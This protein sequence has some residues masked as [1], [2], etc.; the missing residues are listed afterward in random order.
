M[1]ANWQRRAGVAV[2]LAVVGY[3]CALTA[4]VIGQSPVRLP[5]TTTERVAGARWWP[6]RM[7]PM[8]EYAGTGVCA[9]CHRS[10]VESQSRSNMARTLSPAAASEVLR[11]RELLRFTASP[12]TH[13]IKTRNGESTYSVSD[14][15]RTAAVALRWAFGAGKVGQTFLFERGRAMHEGRASYFG[16]IEAL[17]Q[18]PGRA[19]DRPADV[20]SAMGRRLSAGE[21]A[22]CFGCHTSGLSI[23]DGRVEDAVPG[24]TCE[25]CH[26]PGKAHTD[27]M[28]ANRDEQGLAA[29]LNPA[30][31]HPVD[32]VDFCGACHA[33]Y[34]DVTLANEKGIR[35]MRSQPFRLQSS[36]CWD[37]GDRRITCVACH[38]PHEPL[39]REAGAYDARCLSCH[40][41][42]DGA[43]RPAI[44]DRPV[45]HAPA[46]DAP[47][48]RARQS[49]GC[50][51]CH[52]PKYQVAEMHTSFTDHLIRIVRSK[53]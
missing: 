51:T 44:P 23:R 28:R 7:A 22:R 50:A 19:L 14:G 33:T 4:A 29:I 38:D 31:F 16:T 39:K 17:D 12:F 52:M 18:T 10:K 24:V 42:V 2:W 36:R 13:E 46:P 34:W 20:E 32:S 21:T 45:A 53:Q 3:V 40:K 43:S 35:A 8:S 25:G 30:P 41:E 37:E 11:T 6:T 47:S 5:Q 26:G 9:E 27:A 48:C 1:T 15:S 49:A